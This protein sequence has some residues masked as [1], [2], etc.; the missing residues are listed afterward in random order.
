MKLIV[1]KKNTPNGLLLVVTDASLIGKKFS[2]GNLQLDL[3]AEFYVGEEMEEKEIRKLMGEAYMIHFT[4]EEAVG[5]GVERGLVDEKK[6]LVI[7]G[8]KH[9]EVVVEG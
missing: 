4:G 8:V 7:E 5:L 3:G 2:E 6:V 1:S 9:A